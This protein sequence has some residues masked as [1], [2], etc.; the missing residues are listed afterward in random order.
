[1][2]FSLRKEEQILLTALLLLLAYAVVNDYLLIV[3]YLLTFIG[4]LI[5]LSNFS[6]VV[7][8]LIAPKT[9]Q[10]DIRKLKKQIQVLKV[11]SALQDI[12]ALHRR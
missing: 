1:M 7:K 5:L 2:P 8:L 4:A 11:L 3:I 9:R 12:E 6:T 10:K